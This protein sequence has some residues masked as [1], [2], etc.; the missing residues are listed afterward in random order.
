MSW[1]NMRDGHKNTKPIIWF[2]FD[3]VIHSYSSGWKGVDVVWDDPTPGAFEALEQYIQY[4]TVCI[5]SSRSAHPEGLRAMKQWFIDYGWPESSGEPK[6]LLFPIH[7][8]L[9]I[10]AMDD[11][12]ECFDGT[13]P[14]VDYIFGFQPWHKRDKETDEEKE[15]T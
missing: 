11:R 15:K 2:D 8:P 5:L 13:F 14:P 9:A 10:Y 7:K 12:V 6:D 4:F 1:K 3:G